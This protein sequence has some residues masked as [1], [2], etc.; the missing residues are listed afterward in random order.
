M[1]LEVGQIGALYLAN[2]ARRN[3][4]S[5]RSRKVEE[6]MRRL[7]SLLAAVTALVTFALPSFAQSTYTWAISCNKNTTSGGVSTG[8]TWFWMNNGFVING[9]PA[10]GG[11]GAGCSGGLPGGTDPIPETVASQQDGTPKQVNGIQVNLSITTGCCSCFANSTITKSFSP[12]DPIFTITDS[13]SGPKNGG[14]F[15]GTKVTCANG[16]FKFNIQ[17]N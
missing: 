12:S 7:I 6:V 13:I 5:D 17:S 9:D 3:V 11:G 16:N 8:V 4:G 10:V 14:D 15:F 1:L 2:A